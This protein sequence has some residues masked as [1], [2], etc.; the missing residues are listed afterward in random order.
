MDPVGSQLRDQLQAPF[1]FRAFPREPTAVEAKTDPGLL[2]L[3][4][5]SQSFLLPG[6]YLKPVTAIDFSSFVITLLMKNPSLHF[7]YAM[8]TA[9]W[10]TLVLQVYHFERDDV[11]SAKMSEMHFHSG[12][13]HPTA[14]STGEQNE[15]SC[16]CIARH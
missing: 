2:I 13:P 4:D 7:T 8:I 1:K 12:P 16:C 9:L 5:A 6:Y 10:S 15:R 3:G 11:K 14:A